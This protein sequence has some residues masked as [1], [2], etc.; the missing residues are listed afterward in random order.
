MAI[1]G[2]WPC[3]WVKLVGLRRPVACINA[4]H[5][6]FVCVR[7]A[8]GVSVLEVV[9]NQGRQRLRLVVLQHVSG[10]LNRGLFKGGHGLQALVKLCQ[11][12]FAFP[13][14]AE[15][16]VRSFHH[17]NRGADAAVHGQRFFKVEQIRVDDLVC[18][19]AQDAPPAIRARLRPMLGQ[20]V[21]FVLAQSGI[22][23][24]EPCRHTRGVGVGFERV[25][26]C[27]LRFELVEPLGHAGGRLGRLC[28]GHAK[29]FEVDQASD[30]LGAGAR[31][32]HDH[33]AAHAVAN[34]VNGLA[35][36]ERVEQGVQIG[37]VIGE[38]VAVGGRG[39]GQAV[40]APVHG[41]D[42]ALADK[43][44]AEGV[45]HELVRGRHIHP[46]VGQNEGGG[47][48]QGIAPLADVVAAA[49]QRHP[50]AL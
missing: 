43:R 1:I 36:V 47:T 41:D 49:A 7:E 45:D 19:V 12:V 28:G 8:Q 5:G 9:F 35:G 27:A 44:L 50:V 4:L 32:H 26:A 39:F 29:A 24:H 3:L 23:F 37:Q 22:G 31:V 2:L 20:P 40:A 38:P 10:V 14:L 34:Q 48:R 21:G 16:V 17:Q 11:C 13:P 25:V 6:V 15:R 30:A 46:A 33:V 42:G 18:R